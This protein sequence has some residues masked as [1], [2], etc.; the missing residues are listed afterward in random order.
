MLLSVIISLCRGKLVNI[1]NR[2]PH[3]YDVAT[4]DSNWTRA[5]DQFCDQGGV[6]GVSFFSSDNTEYAHTAQA[7]NN[8]YGNPSRAEIANEYFSL[9]AEVDRKAVE[10]VFNKQPFK[11]IEDQEIW[12]DFFNQRSRP[13]LEFLAQ[14]MNVFRRAAYNISASKGWNAI[15][16]LNYG[17]EVTKFDPKH[18]EEANL[19][20]LHLGKALEINRFYSKLRQKYQAVLTMLNYVEVGMCIALKSGEII[21][22][23]RQAE[24][25]LD[26]NDGLC[27]NEY[28][29]LNSFS[30]DTTDELN[31]A[32]GQCALTAIGKQSSP[33]KTILVKR[34]SGSLPY[35]IEITPLRDG[36]D[37]L[38]DNI[39]GALILII[40]PE[41]P[42]KLNS[43]PLQELFGLSNAEI[44][45]VDLLFQGR[46]ENEIADIRNV[47]LNTVKNQRKMIYSKTDVS[48]R[49]QLVRKAAAIS[50]PIE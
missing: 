35:L 34:K 45:I 21:S 32:I 26:A 44:E 37:E 3:I 7:M 19:L 5:L 27:T 25:I 16:S 42:I 12:P 2:L 28:N 46:S 36:E 50:P 6:K 41:N 39:S 29:R 10:Y 20:A 8:Y 18:V 17:V 13:D 4:S 15:V 23:N 11:R 43:K 48:N 31:N 40:D 22:K 24:R 9:F 1:L 49:A 38:N 33:E 14:H 30:C 47:T